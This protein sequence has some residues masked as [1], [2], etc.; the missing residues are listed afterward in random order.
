MLLDAREHGEERSGEPTI[1]HFRIKHDLPARGVPG[2]RC[3]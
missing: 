1:H 2:L 3:S